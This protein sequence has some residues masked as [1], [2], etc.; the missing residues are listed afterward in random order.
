MA[1]RLD[2]GGPDLDVTHEINVTPFIDVILERRLITQRTT[3][4]WQPV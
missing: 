1:G 3:A 2:D 4:S